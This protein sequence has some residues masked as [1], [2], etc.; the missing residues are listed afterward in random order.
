MFYHLRAVQLP[1]GGSGTASTGNSGVGMCG[2]WPAGVRAFP[3][4]PMMSAAAASIRRNGSWR[5][6]VRLENAPA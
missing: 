5:T 2:R 3:A 4:H 6:E 1:G